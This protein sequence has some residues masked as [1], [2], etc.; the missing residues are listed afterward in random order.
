MNH[1]TSS[2]LLVEDHPV[3]R[4]GLATQIR[5]EPDL[6]ICGEAEDVNEALR[7]VQQLHPDLVIV[8]ICLKSG[9]GIDL[10][11]RV[12]DSDPKQRMLVNSMYDEDVY[13]E[14]ALQAGAMGV[15]QQAIGTRYARSSHPNPTCRKDLFESRNDRTDSP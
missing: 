5:N 3:M 12:H 4:D 2:I 6:Q 8:D 13:A 10:V 11:R 15:P 1:G 7:L 9:H 14:R